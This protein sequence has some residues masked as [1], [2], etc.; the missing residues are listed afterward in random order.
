MEVLVEQDEIAP[1]GIL[2]ELRGC[3]IN[4]AAPVAVAQEDTRQPAR[5]LFGNLIKRHLPSRASWTFDGEAIAVV[6]VVLKKGADNQPVDRHP[7]RP[8]PGGV[9]AEHAGVGFRWQI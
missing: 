2:L 7:D 3:A 1:V 8:T 9:A 5:E 6:G 4:G